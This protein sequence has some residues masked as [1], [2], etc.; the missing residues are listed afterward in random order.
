MNPGMGLDTALVETGAALFQILFDLVVAA[1]VAGILTLP[2]F[3]GVLAV[4][5]AWFW[6]CDVTSGGTARAAPG[7]S[8]AVRAAGVQPVRHRP[9]PR[10][11]R[12]LRLPVPAGHRAAVQQDGADPDGH[13]GP[14]RPGRPQVRR[15]PSAGP[16][17]GGADQLG[18]LPGRGPRAGRPE[19][20]RTGPAAGPVR[21]Q[22]LVPGRPAGLGGPPPG[23]PAARRRRRPPSP[24]ASASSS[25]T[26]RRVALRGAAGESSPRRRSGRPTTSTTGPSRTARPNRTGSSSGSAASPCT[27]CSC[28]ARSRW[29]CSARPSC[30]AAAGWSSSCGA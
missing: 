24:P 27:S 1:I 30:S 29:P 14:V 28:S 5:V 11:L 15:G 7:R 25:A 22:C 8:P 17:A 18:P 6:A 10:L 20:P 23:V 9:E 21:S 19:R 12:G 4:K 3:Y 13:Q 16:A 2:L 26:P